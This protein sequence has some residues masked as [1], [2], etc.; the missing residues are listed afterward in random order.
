M[1]WEYIYG[2]M[3]VEEQE[4]Q[5][6]RT[7]WPWL[8]LIGLA[9]LV[10]VPWAAFRL[11]YREVRPLTEW[12]LTG[13]CP[14]ASALLRDGGEGR[15]CFDTRKI[16][17]TKPGEAVVLVAGSAGPRI[18]MVRQADTTAPSAR[19]LAPV[20]GLDDEPGPE[21]FITDLRDAQ[22]VGVSFEEPPRFHEPG[23]WP[24][25]VRLEDLS[26]N[27]SLVETSC[28]ILGP[29]ARLDMEAGEDVPPLSAFLP[30]D[31]ASGRFLTDMD[32]LDTRTPGV[33]TVQVEARG[34]V[35]ET[36][37]VIADTVAPR[38]AFETGVP[39]VRTGQ[40]LAPE[41]L[42]TDAQDA[43]ALTYAFD[44]QPDWSRQGYQDVQ[45]V[46]TDAGGNQTRGT[47]TVLVSDLQPLVW[48]ASRRS[49][50]GIAVHDRQRA[51]DESFS[52]EVKTARFVPK[53]LGCYDI[54][55][56]VDEVPCIQRLFVVD[57]AAPYLAFPRKLQAYLDHPQPPAALLETAED[58]TALTLSYVVEPDWTREGDQPVTIAA[59]DAAGNRTE[60][61]GTVTIVRDTEKPL[62]L[63]A[64]NQYVYIG[65]PV[66]YFAHVS[67]SDNADEPE[68]VVVTVDNSAVDI[69]TQGT[70]PVIYRATDRAGNTA[71]KQVYLYFIRPS[72]SDEKLNEKADQV[73]ASLVT[74]DMTK[75]QK[76][77][78]IYRYVYD[79]Y[80]FRD[81]SSN[82]RDWK[83]E[84]WRGLTTR[85]GDCFTYCAAAKILLEKI[86]AKAMFV[87][88]NHAFRHYWLMVDVGT[89]W[90]HFD[91]LN[92]GPSRKFQCFMLTT[93]QVL[94][95]Y[96]FFWKYD[97]R[98]YPATPET[99]FVK[100]W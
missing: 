67:A 41:D 42:V 54:I 58:A 100:D 72:V 26:G 40:A 25:I 62:I 73:L 76:A 28:T 6:H 56:T 66:A 2:G 53:A 7:R 65:E 86:G 81:N 78:A 49:V 14:P 15:W 94:D 36:A 89:G 47:V 1:I 74:D 30:R 51:L 63:G 90:Y 85:R 45:V 16:D 79:T 88:R 64:V 59:V 22:L 60:A 99:P 96:P 19:A 61:E 33:R 77:Y 75:G 24:V 71:E 91:P 21:S 55:A 3:A 57:T 23:T 80:T 27:V 93:G 70:Y 48:E 4:R 32:A 12:E 97:Q 98:I 83:Y 34:Q 29:V 82:K 46:V 20:L 39:Y 87:T 95:L 92:S 37:L 38:C 10:A 50:T 5:T 8:L 18:A 9:L 43:S 35:Y 44:P 17:W 84:A 69:Y 13:E 31:T 52:G 11:L 68:D